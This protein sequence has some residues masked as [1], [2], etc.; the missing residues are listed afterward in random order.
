[1]DLISILV[2]RIHYNISRIEYM[3]GIRKYNSHSRTLVSRLNKLITETLYAI[4]YRKLLPIVE[5]VD[6]QLIN[7]H[8][9]CLA[10]YILQ[11]TNIYKLRRLRCPSHW[12]YIKG[13]LYEKYIEDI[14][15]V[16]ET[17]RIFFSW[18]KYEVASNDN[19]WITTFSSLIPYEFK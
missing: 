19:L 16:W 17:L 14:I 1:M 9:L 3:H 18:Q 2:E 5:T 12:S 8:G 11:F 10:S 6:V 4:K 7:L 15:T 13:E